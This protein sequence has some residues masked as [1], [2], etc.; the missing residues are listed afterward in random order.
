MTFEYASNIMNF[1]EFM[2]AYNINNAKEIKAI[3]FDFDDT[4]YFQKNA[5]DRYLLY[6]K[7]MVHALT[8]LSMD[9][10]EQ[11]FVEFNY[12][13]GASRPRLRELVGYFGDFKNAY[14]KFRTQ[15]FYM[16][17]VET[18]E[19]VDSQTLNRFRSKY[20]LFLVSGEYEFNVRKKADALGIDLSVFDEVN[21]A[22]DPGVNVE[23][24]AIYQG[25]MDKY[26]FC[27]NQMCAIGDR[28]KV[29]LEPMIK[30]GG[31]GFLVSELRDFQLIVMSLE[32]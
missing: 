5:E 6:S 30:L 14:D 23:K 7:N 19:I 2:E 22:I 10:I 21:G 31:V 4:M 18:T 29:D 16:P 24:V 32:L 26:G 1:G 20:K 17:D 15:Y 13:K 12:V 11:K 25:L 9:I 28:Y 27:G 3:V 8:G